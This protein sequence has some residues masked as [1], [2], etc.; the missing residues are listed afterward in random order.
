MS[1][2]DANFKTEPAV[3]TNATAG[4][5]KAAAVFATAIGFSVPD[6]NVDLL[7]DVAGGGIAVALF[8]LD[9]LQG[10]MI[11][12][13]VYSPETVEQIELAFGLDPDEMESN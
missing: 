13:K 7:I 11:R 2:R 9:T 5:I 4:L 3:L 12:R 6:Q 1:L 10:F 8:A